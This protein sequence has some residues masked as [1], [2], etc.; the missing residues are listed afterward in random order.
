[1][2]PVEFSDGVDG[3]APNEPLSENAEDDE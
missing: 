1:M 3:G 2:G